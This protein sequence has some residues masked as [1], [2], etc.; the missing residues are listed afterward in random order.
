M[1]KILLFILVLLFL[2]LGVV[3]YIYYPRLNL[4]TGFAAKN[5]C[6]CVYEAGREPQ[7]VVAQD[8]NFSPVDLLNTKSTGK[9]KLPLLAF[10]DLKNVLL[11]TIPVWDVCFFPKILAEMTCPKPSPTACNPHLLFLIL[12]A[13]IN[14]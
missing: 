1:R 11:C 4:I 8:N 9:T 3:A 7:S 12:M 5:M 2:A 6:S 14:L 13:I 10:L